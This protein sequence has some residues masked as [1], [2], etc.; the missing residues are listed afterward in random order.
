MNKKEIAFEIGMVLA[1][2]AVLTVSTVPAVNATATAYFVPQHSNAS[3]GGYEWVY[4]YID[5][6]AGEH[7]AGGQIQL[8][9]D[10]AHANITYSTKACPAAAEGEHCWEGWSKNHNFVGDGYWWGGMDGPQEAVYNGFEGIWEWNTIQMFEGPMLVR[11][12]K[13][14]VEP[15]G[16]PGESPFDFGFEMFPE[17]CYLCQRSKLVKELGVEID[18]IWINGT[19]T[20]LAEEETFNK[21]LEPGWNLISLPLTS[22]N[23]SAAK[24][25]ETVAYNAVYRYSATASKKFESVSTMDPGAGYF[26]NVTA[27]GQTWTYNG[28]PYEQMN[29]SIEPGLNMVGWLNCSKSI[30]DALSSLEG[31]YNYVAMFNA[32]S[33][34]F[35]VY[36]PHAPPVFNDFTTMERG[37][38]YFI[39]ARAGSPWLNESCTP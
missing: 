37:T 5:I 21:P 3:E 24:V 26:V 30:T 34:K 1:V 10:P 20:Y 27:S 25:L 14:R 31:K 39:S 8:N 9:F 17:K 23:N 32:T 15:Q 4:L 13:F 11:F 28:T 38:G 33:K 35:E 2:L 7:L 19:F 29:V 22:S 12:G 18:V 6:P 16:T 36:N